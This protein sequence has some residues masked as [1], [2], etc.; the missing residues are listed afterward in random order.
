MAFNLPLSNMEV[1]TLAQSAVSLQ[2]G[3]LARL[4]PG[5]TGATA[6]ITATL[7]KFRVTTDS[8]EESVLLEMR[9]PNGGQVIY[10]IVP[11]TAQ[12]LAQELVSTVSGMGQNRLP[13]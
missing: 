3:V 5:G 9:T 12:M 13:S 6:V 4:Q 8:L 1:M 11:T 2:A 10:T 7:E